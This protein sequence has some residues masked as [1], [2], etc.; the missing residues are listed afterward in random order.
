MKETINVGDRVKILSPLAEN[1]IGR[2]VSMQHSVN[3]KEP[4]LYTVEIEDTSTPSQPMELYGLS[5]ASLEIL[6]SSKYD[7]PRLINKE[8]LRELLALQEKY[9]DLNNE[10]RR[11]MDWVVNY[12][13][14][15][16]STAIEFDNDSLIWVSQIIRTKLRPVEKD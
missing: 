10:C 7:S 8:V 16:S 11:F 6:P 2:V 3:A 13:Q 9:D 15:T 5:T 4:P 12:T 1:I 14:D